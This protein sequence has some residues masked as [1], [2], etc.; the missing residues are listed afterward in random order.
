MNKNVNRALAMLLAFVMV[1]AIIAP[2][3][4][5]VRETPIE[6]SPGYEELG[7]IVDE[8]DVCT[9]FTIKFIDNKNNVIKYEPGY[10]VV[11]TDGAEGTAVVEG[12][13]FVDNGEGNI[14][15]YPNGGAVMN[16]DTT[17][18]VRLTATAI[19]ALE[20]LTGRSD[21]GEKDTAFAKTDKDGCPIEKESDFYLKVSAPTWDF[22]FR[23]VRTDGT[24][25]FYPVHNVEL[26]IVS[27]KRDTKNYYVLDANKDYTADQVIGE[28]K[29]NEDGRAGLKDWFE[30]TTGAKT[31]ILK[32]TL[33]G[34]AKTYTID[35]GEIIGVRYKA[36]TT[37]P[38]GI[39][40]NNKVYAVNLWDIDDINRYNAAAELPEVDGEV[41]FRAAN[42]KCATV[43]FGEPTVDV[44]LYAYI[45]RYANETIEPVEG[46]VFGIYR[47][48]TTDTNN[49]Y[50]TEAEP[51]A[52]VTTDANGY[53]TF[54]NIPN[55]EFFNT[56]GYMRI[57]EAN[58]PSIRV[59]FVVKQISAPANVEA[60]GYTYEVYVDFD[61]SGE[62]V[63]YAI[64]NNNRRIVFNSD[65]N[66]KTDIDTEARI[67][68]RML[69]PHFV[70][71]I[72]RIGGE[73]RYGT[74]AMIA[75]EVY[76]NGLKLADGNYNIVIAGGMNFPDALGGMPMT[77]AYDAPMLLT[78]RDYIPQETLDFIKWA[79]DKGTAPNNA[80]ILGGTAVVS[81][82]VA[83]Q[84]RSM[85]IVT[86]RVAD[87][88]YPDRYGT[89]VQAGE[90]LMKLYNDNNRDKFLH[91][92][93]DNGRV[94]IANGQS[95]AD[96]LTVSVPARQF[97]SPILLTDKD[98][99][100]KVTAEAL[101]RWNVKEVVIVGGV[102]AVSEKVAAQ[103]DGL[104]LG[105]K[106]NRL[107]GADRNET[108]MQVA[109]T[110]YPQTN[111]A[112]IARDDDFAD[113]LAGSLLAATRQAPILL[114]KTNSVPEGVA[115]Y[116]TNENITEL[117]I[118]GGV[119]A[120]SDAVRAELNRIILANY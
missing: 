66:F 110:Y 77:G 71:S 105:I 62:Q 42:N 53:A 55:N 35:A 91:G 100:P 20:S 60:S 107:F 37:L 68:G 59:P 34:V 18:T 38:N 27:L 41:I 85:G 5:A 11:T 67:T 96:A 99:L 57:M 98:N 78:A 109:K 104:G 64:D 101:D 19:K 26:E 117:T 79:K 29:T 33:A 88:K 65:E 74:A 47:I 80:I 70:D 56:L 86:T 114:V 103:I 12:A 8:N 95:F 28:V 106:V 14:K 2:T 15:V 102:A 31:G 115:K 69:F 75:K 17:Y 30:Y 97:G 39:K 25:K 84:L 21:Y 23:T 72:K 116:L 50:Q 49:K 113:S 40:A 119:N 54:K 51:F 76:P 7:K 112:F 111:E 13:T 6:P 83:T 61:E 63:L 44:P 46:A 24:V 48:T 43:V 81:E 108:A 90:Q 4:Q 45:D 10:F 120:V 82:K 3:A 118:L 52:K 94:F 36:G 89:A 1:F 73:N 16:A 92:F 22:C 87:A 32:T 9:G 93:N 58:R